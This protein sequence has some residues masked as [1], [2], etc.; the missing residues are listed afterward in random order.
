MNKDISIV[1]RSNVP[2]WALSIAVGAAAAGS[3]YYYSTKLS[4]PSTEDG[5][6]TTTPPTNPIHYSSSLNF[7]TI[8]F[9][10]ISTYIANTVRNSIDTWRRKSSRKAVSLRV[11]ITGSSKGFGKALAEQFLQNGDSVIL[12]GRSRETLLQLKDEYHSLTRY[13]GK[14]L[15]HTTDVRYPEQ[16]ESLG[17]YA[18][19]QLGGIDLWINNAG[20][21][22]IH[23]A[24]LIK[25]NDR[26]IINILSTNLLGTVLGTKTAITHMRNQLGGG[27]IVFVDGAGT[28]CHNN[29]YV[30]STPKNAVYGI[31]KAPL[32]QLQKT[33]EE[34]CKGT[35]IGI[36]IISPGMMITDLLLGGNGRGKILR[37]HYRNSHNPVVTIVGNDH[38]ELNTNPFH[39]TPSLVP[40][41][42][43]R[44]AHI[45]NILAEYPETV[46]EYMVPRLRTLT[47]R[48]MRRVMKE[49]LSI[50]HELIRSPPTNNS[51][52]LTTTIEEEQQQQQPQISLRIHGEYLEYLTPLSILWR[53]LTSPFRHNRLLPEP[54]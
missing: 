2:I 5:I 52:T 20:V 29:F 54:K 33:M 16:V 48:T 15:I 23:K 26:T 43:R 50:R 42:N 41:L 14:L 7:N 46:A 17:L 32:I 24:P 8:T 38:S 27:S 12:T 11:V 3:Y 21:S 10:G 4:T 39:T 30:M 53:F 9:F 37:D 22:A 28:S 40:Y 18:K 36:H 49:R 1:D 34:E 51:D 44:T 19:Q 13:G 35:G 31:T 47:I 6:R 45:F 25:T